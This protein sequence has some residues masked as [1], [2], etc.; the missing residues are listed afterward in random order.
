MFPEVLVQLRKSNLWTPRVLTC[1]EGN[2]EASVKGKDV[3]VRRSPQAVACRKRYALELGKPLRLQETICID[4]EA[5]TN[6][7]ITQ[8]K[9][10]KVNPGG[11]K[12]GTPIVLYMPKGCLIRHITRR[13]GKPTTWG[14]T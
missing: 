7:Y 2:T 10:L 6:W 5:K 12:V 11:R 8:Q 4:G 9:C 1:A 14:R 3:E 13:W